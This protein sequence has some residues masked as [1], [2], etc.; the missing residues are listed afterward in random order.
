MKK[1]RLACICDSVYMCPGPAVYLLLD[2]LLCRCLVDRTYNK[3]NLVDVRLHPQYLLH[4]NY[5]MN[6]CRYVT[7]TYHGKYVQQQTNKSLL[8]LLSNK[9]QKKLYIYY[10][11]FDYICK[12]TVHT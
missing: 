1:I 4:K 6:G 2:A 3:V 5:I 10:Y 8:L 9:R 12:D 7:C 11:F